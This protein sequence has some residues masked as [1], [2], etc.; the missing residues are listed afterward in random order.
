MRLLLCLLLST[1]FLAAQCDNHTELDRQAL[2]AYLSNEADSWQSVVDQAAAL[3][4][5]T[6]NDLYLAQ[7]LFG[8]AGSAFGRGDEVAADEL[9]DRM[10]APLKR[11]LK[12]DK[13]HATANAL[14]SGYLGML[15]AQSPMKGML[16][17][18]KAGRMA[19]SAPG[20]GPNDPVAHY[21]LGS[22][23]YYTPSTWGGDPEG[24]VTSLKKALAAFPPTASGCDWFY[25]QTYAL[26]GQA[27]AKIGDKEAARK[28]YLTALE[29]QPEFA[30][31]E[32]VLLPNLE[33]TK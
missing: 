32:H 8:A 23:L 18:R 14:Y 31:V 21:F 13:Q 5:S 12:T 19:E 4:Q 25:L 30:W 15:I 17:G 33:K 7:L 20:Y 24:A 1:A 22:N 29:V 3:P 26:L 16:Y 11:V 10:E 6:E 2:A 9:T 27:Q 28:T